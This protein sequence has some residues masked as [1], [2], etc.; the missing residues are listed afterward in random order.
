MG[1]LRDPLLLVQT[2]GV[3]AFFR[4]AL[5]VGERLLVRKVSS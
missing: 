5:N 3:V 4:A 2:C 1:G